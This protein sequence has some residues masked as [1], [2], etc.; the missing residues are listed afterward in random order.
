M[1]RRPLEQLDPVYLG[2]LEI[3]GW[4]WLAGQGGMGKFAGLHGRGLKLL[5]AAGTL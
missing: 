2:E 3:Q 5:G 1:G 4:G